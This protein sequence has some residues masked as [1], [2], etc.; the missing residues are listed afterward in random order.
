MEIGIV[1]PVDINAEVQRAYL[2][3]AMSVIVSRAI[4]DARDGLKPVQR[5]ILY[6]MYDMGIRPTTA[7]KKSARIV[8]EVLGKYHPHGDAA[9]YDAMAR[10][11]Q[12]FSVRYML[13]DGQ[14]NFGSIDGDPPAAMRYTEARLAAISLEALRDID[15]ATVDWTDNFDGT[16]TEPVVLP[17]N[18]P[19]L[20]V[21]GASGIAVG[22]ST[23]IPPH[24]LGEV[25]DALVYL[26][27][28]WAKQEDIGVEE[29]LQF[30]LGPD[31]PTGAL[32]YRRERADGDDG[33]L[34]AYATGRGRVTIRAR[35]HTEE[36]KG[37]RECIVITEIPYQIN[38]TSLI[39]SI[40]KLARSG[41]LEGIS[42][43]RD[44]SDRQGMRLVIDL[45]R[46]ADP[47]KILRDLYAHTTLETRFGIILLALVNGEPRVLSLKKAL[48]VFLDHRLEVLRRRSEHD[49][50]Q[51]RRRAHIVEG[52]L[53]ALDNLD[54]I[55]DTIRRSRTVE[56]ARANLCRKFKLS[57]EQAQAIL[58]MPLK[59]LAA[60]E[61]RKLQ[62][63]FKELQATIHDL[64]A[65]LKSPEKQRAVIR[66]ELLA[67]KEHYAD[68]RR[69]HILDV[70]GEKVDL[71]AL[72]PD[73][74]VWVMVGRDGLVGRAPDEGKPPRVPSRPKAVPVAFVSASTRDTL[75]LFTAEGTAVAL[76]VHQVPEG[77]VWQGEGAQFSTLTR[78][79]D[80]E[81]IAALALPSEPPEGGALFFA[82]ALGQV[83]R[84]LSEELPGVGREPL[85][86]IR[87]DEGDWLVGL[88]WV[89]ENDEIV[90]GASSGQ[91]IRFTVSEVRPTGAS[92]GGMAGMRLGEADVVVG[93]TVVGSRAKLATVTDVGM[94]KCTMFDDVP[95]QRRGGKGIQI[96]KVNGDEHLAGIGTV[97][98]TSYLVLVTQ[99]AA[100][101][102]ITARSVKEQGRATRGAAVIALRDHDL[103]TG[104]IVPESRIE[105]EEEE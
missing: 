27:D 95:G 4:P 39:E 35:A 75:Y 16:L 51:A 82:T 9:V 53:I 12:D 28:N 46:G 92:A 6:A 90:L 84:M 40:A 81:V 91:G 41:K 3:Y 65:L 14:G 94:A 77:E 89:A 50:E 60:L 37:G 66:Q 78:L 63:E 98:R 21:N 70:K 23:N 59:R 29:L 96:A 57:E 56:T 105:T 5:R 30:I 45:G 36:L 49:L 93:L 79:E 88:A 102:T 85:P 67:V 47:D 38:R 20:L 19:N 83:K 24:N 31:F 34:K 86:V 58:D 15:K 55:I 2:D 43:L 72:I 99:R 17:A 100:A 33:L 62:D 61:R 54:E 101:K 104:V 44:E 68:P 64:E 74:P 11:A 71:D 97:L 7:Y 18:L 26:L 80:E 10:L 87:L 22:M 32:V 52:L 73:E 103:V 8:G 25:V 69:T 42:D 1:R 13:V 76:P 48:L